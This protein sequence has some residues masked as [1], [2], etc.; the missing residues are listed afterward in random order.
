MFEQKYEKIS[1]FLSENSDAAKCNSRVSHIL[2]EVE[3]GGSWAVS[4][5]N[6]I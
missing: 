4:V 5:P 1:E 2:F 6:H 3:K